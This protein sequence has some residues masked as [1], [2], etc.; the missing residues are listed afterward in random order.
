[1]TTRLQ[2]RQAGAF[3]RQ[4]R[5]LLAVNGLFITA[6]ALSGTYFGIYIW[7]ASNDYMR[8]G[9][10]TL[11]THV[12]MGLTFWIAGNA[13]KEGNKM[14]LLRLGIG[15][16][17]AFYAI[18]LLLKGNAIHYIWLLGIIQG[19]A[20][21]LFWLAFNVVY[22]EATEPDNRDR[23]NGWTGTIGSLV[24]IVVPW[25]SGFL[26]SKLG[27]D[28][29]YRV[30]FILSLCI[31][32]AGIAVS[33]FLRNRKTKGN[34]DWRWPYELL[35]DPGTSW[36]AVLG[37][38]ASQGIRESVFGVIIGVL[39]YVQTGSEMKLGNFMLVTS[40][41]GFISFLIAGKRLKPEWRNRGM[42]VGAIALVAA[43]LPLFAGLSY[44]TLLAFGVSAAL[45]FPL[46]LLPMTS[47][48]FDLIGRDEGSVQRRV[49]F[50]VARELAL[51]VGRIIG[52]TVFMCT[53]SVSKAPAVIIWLL[54]VVGSS[55]L[56][57]WVFMRKV[58]AERV[59]GTRLDAKPKGVL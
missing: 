52:M 54:L 50:V 44:A 7:K 16:S 18:V 45:F 55:P 28:A 47:T 25:S 19:M 49:E 57:S 10:F 22:F 5:L 9:W 32:V 12:A 24:G 6:G 13:A 15:I 33:F 43:V 26:I 56:L 23:F 42:L 46:Y 39:I 17:A 31:F 1:M 4:T 30:I 37:G 27:G 41:V 35:K 11:I 58:L 40:A 29:G 48:V 14:I 59:N 36:R 53:I 20:T 38:L 3:D 8:L 2:H 51:N 21:G 34:Y